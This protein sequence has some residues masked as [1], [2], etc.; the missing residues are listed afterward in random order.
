MKTVYRFRREDGMEMVDVLNQD[1]SPLTLAT[2][3]PRSTVLRVLKAVR[4]DIHYQ[5]NAMKLFPFVDVD[6]TKKL[7]EFRLKNIKDNEER[8]EAAW[9]NK[10]S[11]E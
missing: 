10:G 1:G 2:N 8:H 3:K 7:E 4:P 11:M 9:Y 5:Y 6:A